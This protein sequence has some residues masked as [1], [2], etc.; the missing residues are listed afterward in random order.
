MLQTPSKYTKEPEMDVDLSPV[1][2]QNEPKEDINIK[3]SI[4]NKTKAKLGAFK[5]IEISDIE[6]NDEGMGP[7]RPSTSE[8]KQSLPKCSLLEFAAKLKKKKLEEKV[9]AAKKDTELSWKENEDF[10]FEFDIQIK[11]E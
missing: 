3:S 9:S 8:V 4:S 10:E 11:C 2:R 6:Q 7:T 1:I 5:R